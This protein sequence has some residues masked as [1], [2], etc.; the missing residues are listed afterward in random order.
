MRFLS[1][2]IHEM[3]KA[4]CPTLLRTVRPLSEIF[5][6]TVPA[7]SAAPLACL[8]RKLLKIDNFG[9]SELGR[10]AVR[11]R[12]Q[13]EDHQE[14]AHPLMELGQEGGSD[15]MEARRIDQQWRC[16]PLLRAQADTVYQLLD[17]RDERLLVVEMGLQL[18]HPLDFLPSAGFDLV[19]MGSGEWMGEVEEKHRH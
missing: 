8:L 17:L 18:D 11:E 16:L 1:Y 12:L 2:T 7:V 3:T 4:S 14:V 13:S 9:D 10:R 15:D 5:D 6:S 19:Q